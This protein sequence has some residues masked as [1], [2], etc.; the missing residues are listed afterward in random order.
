MTPIPGA[1]DAELLPGVRSS[2]MTSGLGEGGLV[3]LLSPD[4]PDP[5]DAAGDPAPDPDLGVRAAIAHDYL[6]VRGGAERVVLA[7]ARAFPAAPIHTALYEPSRTF[8]DFDATRIRTMPIDRVAALRRD[9]RRALPLLASVWSRHV[10]DADVVVCSTSGWAHGVT[11]SGRKVVYCHTPARWLYQTDRYLAQSG[12][13]IGRALRTIRPA[14]M[15]W[16]RH[17]AATAT[18]YLANSRVVRDRIAEVYGIEAEVVPAPH[19]V[20]VTAPQQPV[21]GI[22]SGY[23]LVVAR[24]HPYKNVDV[25]VDAF[26][27]MPDRRLVV[28]GTGPDEARLRARARGNVAFAG[29]VDDARLRWLYAH[30]E[31]LVAA[32]HEDYGLTPLEA[33]AFGRPTVALRWGGYLDTILEGRTGVLVDE[34]TPAALRDG[35]EDLARTPLDPSGLRAHAARF[36]EPVFAA[37]LR[38]VV[39]DVARRPA[40]PQRDRIR[41]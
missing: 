22:R 36:S 24:L 30:C 28:V 26:A 16:D 18:R 21:P 8:P 37:R 29:R 23:W 14:L 15:R 17:A 1:L 31:G 20:D 12:P 9:H 38:R 35:V 27:R 25:V 34:P 2:P 4:P 6:T 3:T 19:A 39:A 7:L 5:L 33:A 40:A 41:P 11:T 32:S 10:V 13:A